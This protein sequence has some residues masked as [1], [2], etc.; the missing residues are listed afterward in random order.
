MFFQE[1]RAFLSL[2]Q[3]ELGKT[4]NHLQRFSYLMNGMEKLT[5]PGIWTIWWMRVIY[6]QEPGGESTP[7]TLLIPSPIT[8][9]M[10]IQTKGPEYFRTVKRTTAPATNDQ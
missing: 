3:D 9:M 7:A 4:G 1:G 6:R 5:A 8:F 10:N 2:L